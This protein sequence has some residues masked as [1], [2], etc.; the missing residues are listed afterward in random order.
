MIDVAA[1]IERVGPEFTPATLDREKLAADLE[2]IRDYDVPI[3]ARYKSSAPAK[4]VKTRFLEIEKLS[5][6]L[7]HAIQRLPESTREDFRLKWPFPTREKPLG[8]TELFNA[9]PELA[10]L[11]GQAADEVPLQGVLTLDRSVFEELVAGRLAKV[12]RE[13]FGHEPDAPLHADET[14]DSP[15]VRFVLATLP[16]IGIAKTGS[17]RGNTAYSPHAVRAALLGKPRR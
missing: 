8:L 10:R 4:A 5:R 3:L 9:I 1:I 16:E 12:F 6:R 7:H 14:V 17:K 2:G 13:H 15:F 11:A